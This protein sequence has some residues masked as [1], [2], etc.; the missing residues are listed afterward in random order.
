MADHIRSGS[1]HYYVRHVVFVEFVTHNYSGCLFNPID[2]MALLPVYTTYYIKIRAG[3]FEDI[4]VLKTTN[5]W[6]FTMVYHTTY[7]VSIKLRF[8]QIIC[9]P[10]SLRLSIG[11]LSFYHL[12]HPPFINQCIYLRDF[13]LFGQH[14]CEPEPFKS[15][16]PFLPFVRFFERERFWRTT[17]NDWA[18]PNVCNSLTLGFYTFSRCISLFLVR[19]KFSFNFSYQPFHRSPLSRGRRATS[20]QRGSHT[21]LTLHI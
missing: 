16:N 19:R 8:Y 13:L 2:P 10:F 4:V 15:A 12:P 1:V 5:E 14:R 7:K 20:Y 18:I 11:S 17:W 6:G 9:S 3:L 21:T